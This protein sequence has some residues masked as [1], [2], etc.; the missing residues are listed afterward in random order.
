MGKVLNRRKVAK[1]LTIDI[2]EDHFSYARNAGSVAGE[3]VL[4]GIYAPASPAQPGKQ[5][6][7]LSYKALAQV[8]RAFRAFGLGHPPH[9]PPAS[10][11]GSA[12]TCSCGCCR[13]TS[14]GT[15]R[16]G[17]RPSCS[18]TTRPPP[19]PPGKPCRPRRPLP[20]GT[21]KAATKR[22]EDNPSR[23]Q[24]RQPASRPG[25]H[26]P[27]PD[28]AR[29]PALPAFQLVTTPTP[30]QGQALDLLGISHRLGIA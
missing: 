17:L 6:V 29:R 5:R 24:L 26:L 12:P 11:T 3:A 18:P 28:P 20:A 14:P 23:A 15:C 16:P 30:L 27:Q 19:R 9:P 7:V 22:T 4:D 10:K 21:A 2:G 8:E 1:H 13:T 25:H